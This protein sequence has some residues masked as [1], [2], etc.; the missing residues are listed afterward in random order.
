M[1]TNGSI[2]DIIKAIKFIYSSETVHIQPNYPAGI[3]ILHDGE[4][5]IINFNKYISQVLAAG[6][7]YDTRELFNYLE[8]VLMLS[9]E[10]TKV[11]RN[12]QD[13]FPTGLRYNG[14]FDCDQ[15]KVITCNGEWACDGAI[16][17][18]GVISVIGTIHDYFL[19][20]LFCNGKWICNGDE[21]CSGFTR[22]YEE[23]FIQLPV[24][25][26]EYMRDELFVSLRTDQLTDEAIFQD[27]PMNIKI[28]N[29][30]VCDGSKMP[31]CS[32]CDGSIICN[33]AY[34]GY[35]GRYYR[36]ETR[37]EVIA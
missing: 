25:P 29:P 24:L 19:Q 31:T 37:E 21:D 9:E 4:R 13:F 36:D 22:V 26:R 14:R 17:C 32:L 7:S 8:Y 10:R 20:E 1:T 23:E 6:V 18:G 27:L 3:T 5:P 16:N 12:S 15:G 2:N 28:I 34:T 35:D 11:G 33:G 30:L